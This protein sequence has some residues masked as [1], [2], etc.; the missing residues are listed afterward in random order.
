VSCEAF[1]V[2]LIA[3][4]HCVF[5]CVYRAVEELLTDMVHQT[6]FGVFVVAAACCLLPQPALSDDGES[7]SE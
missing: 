2:N 7:V 6:V 1:A 3:L 4:V 5:A